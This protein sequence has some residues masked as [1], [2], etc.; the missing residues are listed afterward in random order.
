M[1]ETDPLWSEHPLPSYP[2]L[3][4]DLSVDVAIIGGGIA[5]LSAAYELRDKDRTV[6]L[7][8]KDR[9]VSGATGYTTAFLSSILDTNM[10]DLI[11][12]WGD[13]KA[14]LL[15]RSHAEA[16]ERVSARIKDES[17]DAEYLPCPTYMYASDEAQREDLHKELEAGMKL[18]YQIKKHEG[19]LGLQH[20]GVLEVGGQA[21]F[22]PRKYLGGI[23]EKAAKSG[24][25]I[26]EATEALSLS[27]ESPV[28]IKTPKGTITAKHVLLATY[29]PFTKP[30]SL[31]FKKALY[32]SYI[33]VG[34]IE[35][36]KL[37]HATYENMANPY[38][39]FRIDP[40]EG[41]DRIIF[42]GADHRS[43]VPVAAEKNFKAVEDHA[44]ETLKG[45]DCA[46]ES[47]WRGYILEPIDGIAYIGTFGSPAIFVAMAFSG[48]GMTYGTIA[49]KMF[50][51]HVL[52]NGSPYTALYNPGRIPDFTDLFVKGRD[53][54]AE[55]FGGAVK[56]AISYSKQ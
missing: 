18:G 22:H 51:D 20:F 54:I 26:F 23:A 13:E 6:A 42:G 21:M 50:A 17:I 55:F 11:T 53:Y 28:I 41:Y 36:G 24:V 2:A 46:F 10:S 39:Y 16:I 1:K 49:G 19:A 48:N 25:Q 15:V 34:R 38:D 56:N 35:Q 8:E 12:M 43:D 37:P 30:L 44:K 29:E 5:G 52:G 27:G 40:G 9:L 4:R 7:I 47:G 31:Y 33:L 14:R 3:D 45:I 32:V